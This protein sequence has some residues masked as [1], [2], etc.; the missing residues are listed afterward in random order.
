MTETLIVSLTSATCLLTTLAVVN[1]RLGQYLNPPLK[2]DI[3]AVNKAVAA[4]KAE[5]ED[6]RNKLS[7]ISLDKGLR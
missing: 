7:R 5:L 2:A 1:Y 4:Q 6:V 3:E